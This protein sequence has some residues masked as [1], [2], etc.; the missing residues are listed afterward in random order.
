MIIDLNVHVDGTEI[1]SCGTNKTECNVERLDTRQC[2]ADEV[3]CRITSEA[4]TTGKAQ[5]V[6][7]ELRSACI[8][9]PTLMAAIRTNEAL[10]YLDT[11][12]LNSTLLFNLL[13]EHFHL[14][15]LLR[16]FQRQRS[17]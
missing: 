8:Q 16:T 5:A 6:E 11:K 7:D 2:H 15:F 3:F 4:H 13:N 9:A 14:P 1:L 10:G 17:K 12:N